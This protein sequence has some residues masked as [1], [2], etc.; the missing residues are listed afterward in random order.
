MFRK[1]YNLIQA[2]FIFIFIFTNISF[3]EVIKSIEIK[4]NKRI[5]NQTILMFADISEGQNLNST[6]LNNILKN[7]YESNFFS[8]VNVKLIENILQIDVSE[9]PVIENI[10]YKGVK[11]DKIKNV[12]FK[13]LKLKPRSSY[14]E[15]FLNEDRKLKRIIT[16]EEYKFW[17]FISGKKFLNENLI[18]FD[19]RLLK[20]FYLNKG[21]YNV[22][23][24]SSF[25]KLINEDEFELIFN[26]DAKDKYYFNEITLKI[27]DDFETENF[28]SLNLIFKSFFCN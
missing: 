5:P 27:P 18:E 19:Q 8:N 1:Y 6:D 23:I 20:N 11:A 15:I 24:N 12:I 4:G 17:K 13:D 2:S 22:K 26:I 7:I 10:S 21:Y 28:Q 3:G 16:S 9:F 25:A 14:N